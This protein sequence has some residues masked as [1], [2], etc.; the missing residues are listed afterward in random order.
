MPVVL[1]SWTFFI[2]AVLPRPARG[3]L[4]TCKEALLEFREPMV[5]GSHLALAGAD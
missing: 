2:S 5:Y 4:C 1:L 3:V